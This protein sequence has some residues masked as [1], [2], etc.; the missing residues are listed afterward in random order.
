MVRVDF[1]E[2]LQVL[3]C[4]LPSTL[5]CG[6]SEGMTYDADVGATV[7]RST[8]MVPWTCFMSVAA[9]TSILLAARN[10]KRWLWSLHMTLTRKEC[11]T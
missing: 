1:V 5:D 4:A 8:S 9:S 3:R 2:S 7:S 6:S 10:R 11:W